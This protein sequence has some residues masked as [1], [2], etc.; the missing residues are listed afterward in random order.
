M[1]SKYCLKLVAGNI[2]FWSIWLPDFS[3]KKISLAPGGP[4]QDDN[5]CSLTLY[6][7]CFVM[8]III[9]VLLAGSLIY[10]IWSFIQEKQDD[11]LNHEDVEQQEEEGLKSKGRGRVIMG[12]HFGWS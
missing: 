5:F 1:I 4:L 11:D 6:I 12:I 2:W 3:V 7:F 10:Y 9:Y 8:L